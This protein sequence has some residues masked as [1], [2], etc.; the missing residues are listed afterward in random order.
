VSLTSRQ[1]A[2]AEG[3]R[4][5][6]IKICSELPEVDVE[7]ANEHLAFRIKKKTL[8]YYLF[9]HHGDGMIAFCCKSSLSEQRR[10]IR[11]DPEAFFVPAYVGSKGWIAVR[12]DL[13]DVDW[14]AVIDL[15]RTAYQ[16]LAPRKLA[17][18]VE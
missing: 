12:L 8:G 1:L 3:R 9:D 17:T 2:E 11:Q 10:W 15:S 4:E 13:E 6:L 16:S 14:D 7:P 18:L 5:K